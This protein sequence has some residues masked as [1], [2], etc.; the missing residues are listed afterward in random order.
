MLK[1]KVQQHFKHQ[2]PV[3][4]SYGANFK[5]MLI[6]HTEETNSFTAAWEI[7]CAVEQNVQRSRKQKDLL[8]EEEIQPKNHFVDENKIQCY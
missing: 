5:L 3:N 4:C 6:R 1:G 8:L 2:K 7:L